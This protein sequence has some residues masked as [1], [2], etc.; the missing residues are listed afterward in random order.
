MAAVK[1][2]H[3]AT[4]C[5]TVKAYFFVP[6]VTSYKAQIEQCLF[7]DWP[8]ITNALLKA[9][10]G[11][12]HEVFLG[13]LLWLIFVCHFSGKCARMWASAHSLRCFLVTAPLCPF[14]IQSC[15]Q[16]LPCPGALSRMPILR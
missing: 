6:L 8:F 1:C 7:P 5:R 11:L 13:L 12:K 2:H 15:H 4:C 10:A 14:P 9:F 3:R 16:S